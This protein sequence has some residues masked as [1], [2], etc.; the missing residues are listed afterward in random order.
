[1]V[2]RVGELT[3]HICIVNTGSRNNTAIHKFSSLL[4]SALEEIDVSLVTI[5]LINGQST[6]ASSVGHYCVRSRLMSR[7]TF[8]SGRR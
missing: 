5:W 7:P 4:S 1:M 6:I 8:R 3:D 2:N